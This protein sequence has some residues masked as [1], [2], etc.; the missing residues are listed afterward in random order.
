MGLAI[1]LGLGC[2]SGGVEDCFVLEIV[3]DDCVEVGKNCKDQQLN[4]EPGETTLTSLYTTLP[5]L[6]ISSSLL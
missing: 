3:G 5:F 6:N 2:D 1:R 4:R